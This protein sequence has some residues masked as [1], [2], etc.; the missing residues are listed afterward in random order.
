MKT[1]E[2]PVPVFQSAMTPDRAEPLSDPARLTALRRRA[3]P[4]ASGEEAFDRLT[5]LA[6]RALRVPIAL[7]SL[8]EADR[9]VFAGCLGLPEPWASWRQTPLSYSFCQHVVTSGEPLLV[10]DARTHPLLLDNKAVLELGVVAY[11]GVPLI[12]SDGHVLGALCG[13]DTQPRVWSAEDVATL[14][15]L[16]AVATAELDRRATAA[17]QAQ[18]Q[19]R[20][21]GLLAVARRLAAESQ[22]ERVLRALV[23]AGVSLLGMDDGGVA[24]WDPARQTLVQ[25]ESFLPS[26][27]AG[28]RLDLAASASGRAAV[29]RRL[30]VVTDYQRVMG[31]TTPAGRAGAQL[32]VALPLQHEGRLLGTLSVSSFAPGSSLANDDATMLELLA[33]LAAAVLVGQERARL[34]GA[35]LAART[36]QH[37]LANA[38]SAVSGNVQLLR[39]ATDLPASL[40]ERADT[41][42]QQITFAAARLLQLQELTAL[43]EMDWGQV[44]RTIDVDRSI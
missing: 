25:V 10:A 5:R 26:T 31:Q 35:L 32:V 21:D 18:Q 42:V 33:S 9:Q 2:S 6:S 43:V 1:P 7:V 34:A 17:E 16:A 40:R 3:P 28:T 4:E 20:R 12:S 15:D 24:R 13:L 22:A 41:A 36:A 30:V 38:L 8:V 39:R 14:R 27:S 37:E 29:E 23:E 19:H 11:A 44:G